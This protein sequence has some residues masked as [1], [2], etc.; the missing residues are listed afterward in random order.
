MMAAVWL[1]TRKFSRSLA[2]IKYSSFFALKVNR[3]QFTRNSSSRVLRLNG[4]R[5][6]WL[7]W[8]SP[9]TR[10]FTS[11][12]TK[13]VFLSL[14]ASSIWMFKAAKLSSS[15]SRL[16]PSMVKKLCVRPFSKNSQ[17]RVRMSH[18]ISQTPMITEKT[19]LLH[20]IRW[21]PRRL[22]PKLRNHHKN[23]KYKFNIFH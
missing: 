12:W 7:R 2:A 23:Y 16:E 19:N 20:V 22:G 4:W 8:C 9:S 6:K 13:S 14:S 18:Q 10:T 21:M 17:K 5:I 3:S 15:S 1:P 11:S